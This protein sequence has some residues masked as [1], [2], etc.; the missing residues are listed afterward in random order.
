MKKPYIEIE[1]QISESP[2]ICAIVRAQMLVDGPDELFIDAWVE[3]FETPNG[4]HI[5]MLFFEAEDAPDLIHMGRELEA[6]FDDAKK[7]LKLASDEEKV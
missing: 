7:A 4:E 5:Q 1:R 6:A 2:P 3:R